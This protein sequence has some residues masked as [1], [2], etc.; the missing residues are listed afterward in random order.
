MWCIVSVDIICCYARC[1]WI[2]GIGLIISLM[3]RCLSLAPSVSVASRKLIAAHQNEAFLI[4]SLCVQIR[5]PSLGQSLYRG[6]V[7]SHASLEKRV[8]ELRKIVVGWVF[9]GAVPLHR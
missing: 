2:S 5:K 8:A 4:E 6:S 1:Q 7:S 9:L 3:H